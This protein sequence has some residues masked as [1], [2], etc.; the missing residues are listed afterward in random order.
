MPRPKASERA[1]YSLDDIVDIAV[2]EFLTRGYDATSMEHLSRA[3]GLT[4][5]SFY[6]H[7]SGKEELLRLGVG[8]ALDALFGVLD[9]P[10][11][12]EGPAVERMWHVLHRTAD[13]VASRLPEVALLIRVRG[14]TETERLA[15]ARRRDFDARMT[16]IVAEAMAEGGIRGD[17]EPALVTRLLFGM[18]NS[19]VEWYRS[20][21]RLDVVAIATAVR[22]IVFEG[23][24]PR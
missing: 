13:T 19:L 14:N 4:K 6:Y 12:V 10:E 24:T 8:R 18:V 7:V 5:A 22:A 3:A 15:L 16:S 1:P 11:A 17:I 20:G 9:E 21:G 23:L 2:G